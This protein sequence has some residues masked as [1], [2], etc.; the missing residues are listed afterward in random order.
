MDISTFDRDQL[1]DIIR[2]NDWDDKPNLNS[3]EKDLEAYLQTKID[4]GE[5]KFGSMEVI[6]DSSDEG[7]GSVE[8]AVA[9]ASQEADSE[10]SAEK[11]ATG[12][13]PVNPAEPVEEERM[14][15]VAVL[16]KV[17]VEAGIPTMPTFDKDGIA[18]TI[19]SV[20]LSMAKTWEKV[21]VATIRG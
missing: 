16:K 15:E 20:P 2:E 19:V 7:T 18:T 14:V 10:E 6:E 4:S 9:A 3:S 11:A 8:D 12:E 21:G 1:K 5:L 17:F 13:R